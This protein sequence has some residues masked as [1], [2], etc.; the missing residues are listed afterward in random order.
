MKKISTFV[1]SLFFAL[2]YAQAP[3][4]FNYQATVKDA[5]GQLVL[6][7][8]VNFRFSI[9]QGTNTS[10]P[11][12]VETHQVPTDNKSQV[13]L[14]IGQG[15]ASVGSFAQID[16]S[17]TPLFLGV[18]LNTGSGYVTVASSDL[19]SVPYALYANKAGSTL[20]PSIAEVIQ[21]GNDANAKKITNLAPPVDP[22]DGVN[23]EYLA[24]LKNKLDNQAL[25]I[26]STNDSLIK[27]GFIE[28]QIEWEKAITSPTIF[29]KNVDIKQ[30]KDGGFI[31]LSNGNNSNYQGNDKTIISRLN[32]T[33]VLLWQKVFDSQT[34]SMLPQRIIETSDLGFIFCGSGK[35]VKLNSTGNIVWQ[36]DTFQSVQLIQSIQ[37][38]NFTI[39]PI[40]S[41]NNLCLT[42]DGIIFCNGLILAKFDNNGNILWQRNLVNNP[43]LINHI[44]TTIDGGIIAIGKSYV[45]IE[46]D[47]DAIM[48]KID[49]NGTIMWSKSFGG[50]NSEDAQRVIQTK[51]GGFVFEGYTNS[52]E[53]NP[54]GFGLWIVKTNE[55]GDLKWQKTH[56]CIVGYG[57]NYLLKNI[58]ETSDLSLI[59]V[60]PSGSGYAIR[61]LSHDGDF[62]WEKIVKKTKWYVN[63]ELFSYLALT[64]DNGFIVAELS[65]QESLVNGSVFLQPTST[66]L[67]LIKLSYKQ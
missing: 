56:E 61:K 48:I 23:I 42:N 7:Q 41:F 20:I 4:G 35:L 11:L 55:L 31:L 65:E 29:N 32:S 46:K 27:K 19:I 17:L 45:S 12:Y 50:I 66:Q 1:A 44:K 21:I 57:H 2:L 33:G 67:K 39:E 34:I 22:K 51:D 64:N 54:N 13:N 36:N 43:S 53:L 62:Q 47:F 3:P 6:N 10:T 16:W 38:I 15:T 58:E 30:T 40:N 52:T 18:E 37:S 14:I 63:Y 8:N 25:K 9:K 49:A 5:A 28:P 59:H 60:V 24:T 26:K